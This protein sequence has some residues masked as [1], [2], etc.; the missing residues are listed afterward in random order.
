MLH[1]TRVSPLHS[2][3]GHSEPFENGTLLSFPP[4]PK[5]P[6]SQ[7]ASGTYDTG[8]TS[9]SIM[10]LAASAVAPN[11]TTN[12]SCQ[13]KS[14]STPT[15]TPSSSAQT[16]SKPAP[17]PSEEVSSTSFVSIL[18]PNIQDQCQV[19]QRE[20]DFEVLSLSW[21]KRRRTFAC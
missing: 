8:I 11:L 14:S 21:K 9:N 18:T 16:A 2:H 4:P 13:V 6:C 5:I 15:Q 20:Y 12:A 1:A 10:L 7:T 3:L 19:R 17:T